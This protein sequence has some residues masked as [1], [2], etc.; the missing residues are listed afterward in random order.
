MGVFLT[1]DMRLMMISIHDSGGEVEKKLTVKGR[2][3]LFALLGS[4]HVLEND[5]P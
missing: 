1:E 4:V 5:L 2:F 3:I